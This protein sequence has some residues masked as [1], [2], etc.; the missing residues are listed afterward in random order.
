MVEGIVVEEVELLRGHRRG[1]QTALAGIGQG[2]LL[3]AP[4]GTLS[5]V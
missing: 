2:C 4:G 3:K 1:Q 5:V